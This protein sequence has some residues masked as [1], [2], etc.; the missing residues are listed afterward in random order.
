MAML[1]SFTLLISSSGNLPSATS[2]SLC[3]LR[4]FLNGTEQQE[5]SCVCLDLD[6]ELIFSLTLMFFRLPG[7]PTDAVQERRHLSH[8]SLEFASLL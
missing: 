2:D 6:R 4:V 7:L 8:R 3:A 5:H 1:L